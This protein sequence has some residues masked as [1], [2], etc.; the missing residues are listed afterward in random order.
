MQKQIAKTYKSQDTCIKRNKTQL[1]SVHTISLRWYLYQHT[2]CFTLIFL[3]HIGLF[4][5][6]FFFFFMKKSVHKI[7]KKVEE[8]GGDIEGEGEMDHFIKISSTNYITF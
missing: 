3:F 6:S 7:Y 5:F 1:E 8:V 2:I 4:F